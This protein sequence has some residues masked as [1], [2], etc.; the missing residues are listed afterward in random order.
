MFGWRKR[1]KDDGLTWMGRKPPGY[2]PL[3][4]RSEKVIEERNKQ[5]HDKGRSVSQSNANK[6]KK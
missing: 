4:G 1:K 3:K 6:K 2:T 5:L